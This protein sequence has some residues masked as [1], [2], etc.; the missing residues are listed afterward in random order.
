MKKILAVLCLCLAICGTT[1]F[2][3]CSNSN[4]TLTQEQVNELLENANNFFTKNNEVVLGDDVNVNVNDEVAVETKLTAKEKLTQLFMDNMAKRANAYTLYYEQET[5]VLLGTAQKDSIE[6][7][8]YTMEDG[9]IR[10]IMGSMGE[11]Y[12]NF[13]EIERTE[14]GYKVTSYDIMSKTYRVD[15]YEVNY[16]MVNKIEL[17]R[18][19]SIHYEVFLKTF[20]SRILTVDNGE[21]YV[22]ENDGIF[23]IR[24][25]QR[26]NS[27]RFCIE[28]TEI[29]FEEG[30]LKSFLNEGTDYYN[31]GIGTT[32]KVA[33]EISYGCEEFDLENKDQYTLAQ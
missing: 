28:K 9:T 3:G 27:D 16:Y 18:Y 21:C 11:G 7:K 33:C 24:H 31:N 25:E 2:A 8:Y 29:K 10:I 14:T 13:V 20:Y 17:D 32:T 15:N 22:S 23:T 30:L 6:L 26:Y 19:V 12:T 4:V 1:L 5:S